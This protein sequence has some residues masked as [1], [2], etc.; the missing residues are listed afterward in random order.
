MNSDSLQSKDREARI[1]AFA[2]GRMRI[3]LEILAAALS[4]ALYAAIFA[5]TGWHW[6]AWFGMVPLYC[7]I[8]GRNAK[9]A[10][11]YSYVWGY[12]WSLF[13]FLWLREIFFPIPFVFAF[14]LGLFPALWGVTV[15]FLFRNF[16]IPPE[17]RL[18]GAG[19]LAS[20]RSGNPFK[21]IAF[22][23][24]L[25]GLWCVT[26]WLRSWIFTG[27]PWNLVGS[28]QWK[29][30]ALIQI[31][32]YTGVYGVSFLAGMVNFSLGVF[33][34]QLFS[35]T[36]KNRRP[37][38]IYSLIFSFALIQLVIFGCMKNVIGIIVR[39]PENS[40]LRVG[41]VQP[42]LSQRRSGG[43]ERTR[44]AI[45]VCVSL[46]EKLMENYG[47][48]KATD[49]PA[50]LVWPESSVP[51]PYN[52]DAPLSERYRNEVK[53]LNETYRIPLL[54]GSLYLDWNQKNP[55]QVDVYN[56]ALFIRSGGDVEDL[57]SKV[58]IVPFGEYVPYGETFPWLNRLVGMGRNLSRG[59]QFRP[60]EIAPGVR[61]GIAICY[62]DVFAYISRAHALNGA[63][64]LLVVTNDAWYPTSDEPIQHFA[65]SVFR[66]VETRLPMLRCGNSNYSVVIDSTGRV[67]DS[68]RKG[69]PGWTGRQSGTL[70]VH[71][72]PNPKPTF[73]T[74]YGDVFI[75]FC[76]AFALLIFAAAVMNWKI[77][78]SAFLDAFEKTPAGKNP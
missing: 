52:A 11:W 74:L 73:Y 56:S 75:G 14:L 32:E 31:C 22:C 12:F 13:S 16:L 45:D 65:N 23:M 35:G 71:Y 61:A 49:P 20:W 3:V 26:E 29:F 68:I 15:P 48:G 41:V 28:S 47:K 30:N 5:G 53:R 62:E 70:Y 43:V 34:Q 4:G 39:T 46:S 77:Y 37:V 60:L 36:D 2:S 25:A 55:E 10:F 40:T 9:K 58:H 42:N 63:N 17:V 21:E 1:L 59:K 72:N 66:T 57:Y 64:L 7:L 8:A 51:V 67:S 19:A 50:L 27:L 33:L 24:A 54:I 76:S 18:K 6:Y 38:R 78:K 44:E 69:E